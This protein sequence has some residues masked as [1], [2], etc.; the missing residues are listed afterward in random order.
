MERKSCA[1]T[2][3]RPN[4]FPWGYNEADKNC[5]ELKAILNA[6]IVRMVEAGV[7]DFLSGMA[8]GVDTW[9]AQS[10]QQLSYF[11]LFLNML[12]CM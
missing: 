7:T 3:H 5:Q 11:H 2:G 8:L 9:A 10:E 12:L 4:S 1:F 6:Q